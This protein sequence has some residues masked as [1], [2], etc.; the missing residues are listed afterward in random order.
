MHSTLPESS[1]YKS[2]QS[3]RRSPPR[4]FHR[5]QGTRDPRGHLHTQG[6]VRESGDNGLGSEL[7]V[8]GALLRLPR[9][10]LNGQQGRY[11]GCGSKSLTHD[12]KP[13]FPRAP[14]P[15]HCEAALELEV[16]LVL[17]VGPA[18]PN[19]YF[20]G[21]MD[22]LIVP[23]STHPRVQELRTMSTIINGTRLAARGYRA[24]PKAH[25][26]IRNGEHTLQ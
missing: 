15:S 12:S 6:Q 2:Q 19:H 9:H 18:S 11:A 1:R 13:L 24:T 7:L 21:P 3:R 23:T 4:P 10:G 26:T 25:Q 8:V 20:Q 17:K 22:K 5:G 14:S 16:A